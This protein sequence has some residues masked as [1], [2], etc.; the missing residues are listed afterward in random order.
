MSD[1]R[2]EH[3]LAIVRGQLR[4]VPSDALEAAVVLEASAGIT[5]ERALDLGK[6]T[7]KAGRVHTRDR[8]RLPA[9]VYQMVDST[10]DT[11]TA[12]L[13]ALLAFIALLASLGAHAVSAW[14]V[15]MVVGFALQGLLFRRYITGQDRLG[16]VRRYPIGILASLAVAAAF[17]TVLS[18]DEL[19][20]AA[21]MAIWIGGILIAERGWTRIYVGLAAMVVIAR[22]FDRLSPDGAATFAVAAVSVLVILAV[23]TT[24]PSNLR[25]CSWPRGLFSAV[26]AGGFGLLI[27]L[28]PTTWAHLAPSV[29]A[30]PLVLALVGSTWAAGHLN[31]LW[32]YAPRVFARTELNENAPDTARGV[33]REV[34]GGA[35]VRLSGTWVAALIVILS[36]SVFPSLRPDLIDALELMMLLFL[37]TTLAVQTALLDTFQHPAA[38]IIA[39]A[40]A[41]GTT[42]ALTPFYSQ[43]VVIAVGATLGIVLATT[44][45]AR[46]IRR[47]PLIFVTHLA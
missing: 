9:A 41:V 40:L 33:V 25:P 22:I 8:G 42:L 47:S 4:R 17:A 6:A 23:I 24:A 31:G 7:V 13:V 19:L 35:A 27:W 18:H 30:I 10:D 16:I 43:T 32:H 46:Q 5:P 38:A 29:A 39:V 28:L 2:T 36:L 44:L 21:L 20:A 11:V 15:A 12:R 14:R 45:L 3:A 34:F 1:M 26:V 37:I